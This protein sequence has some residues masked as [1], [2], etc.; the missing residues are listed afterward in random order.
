MG[1]NS[2]D[3]EVPAENQLTGL[4]KSKVVFFVGKVAF[5]I[6]PN[7][8]LE[9]EIKTRTG[10]CR[11]N[12]FLLPIVGCLPRENKQPNKQTQFALP[13]EPSWPVLEDGFP[14]WLI[15]DINRTQ[16]FVRFV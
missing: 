10:L 15:S 1:I 2:V 9:F 11:S 14:R 12:S 5:E 13:Q 3:L 7:L 6:E 4:V 16:R 8:A